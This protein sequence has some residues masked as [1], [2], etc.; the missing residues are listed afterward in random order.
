[1]RGRER[2]MKICSRS[3]DLIFKFTHKD[4]HTKLISN[5]ADICLVLL[6]RNIPSDPTLTLLS[7][8]LRETS[9]KASCWISPLS[10]SKMPAP[11]PFSS[12][13]RSGG[14]SRPPLRPLSRN[15]VAVFV[16]RPP[17]ARPLR[18]RRYAP[19]PS[20]LYLAWRALT[21]D[22]R[23]CG[24][25]EGKGWA[26]TGRARCPPGAVGDGRRR[27]AVLPPR[28]SS[29]CSVGG[30][31]RESVPPDFRHPDRDRF[32]AFLYVTPPPRWRDGGCGRPTWSEATALLALVLRR[33][34]P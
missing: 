26:T 8:V 3:A 29:Q 34:S 22:C 33:E 17:R 14:P 20:G 6:R 21:S 7:S 30:T 24:G 16:R 13:A 19:S 12:T 1:M 11:R 4:L 10:A 27:G 9:L 2:T 25:R 18:P 31:G 15:L 23:A 28:P 32:S 5:L